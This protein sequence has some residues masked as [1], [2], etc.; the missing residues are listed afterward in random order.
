[1]PLAKID[2]VVKASTPPRATGSFNICTLEMLEGVVSAAEDV[3]VGVIV[4]FAERH[5]KVVNPWCI[6]GSVLSRIRRSPV[7]VVFHLDHAS[8]IDG[9]RMGIEMGCTSVMIDGSRLPLDEN[10]ALTKS[11]A[12]LA[13]DCAIAVEGELGGI[14][15]V[16]GEASGA[17][18]DV[19]YTRPEDAE[20][21]VT[22]TG[23]D[24]LAIAIGTVHG[25]YKRPPN[26]R[27]DI[28]EQIRRLV[29]VPLVL[30][31]GT[32]T[33][34]EDIRRLVSGGIRKINVFTELSLLVAEKMR[35]NLSRSRGIPGA[36]DAIA[37]VAPAVAESTKR[38]IRLFDLSLPESLK[39]YD[40]L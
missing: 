11:V 7:P 26:L 35:A 16:E 33:S 2:D 20:R 1:M 40:F 30:H 9:V 19:V 13:H 10:I 24:M 34:D 39:P 37:G 32:G 31:G 28:L 12:E 21:F 36:A 29:A 6:A 4:G 17:I 5:A 23:V 3:G 18:N 8:S 38:F 14:G 27:F 22:Q 25:L 15:G